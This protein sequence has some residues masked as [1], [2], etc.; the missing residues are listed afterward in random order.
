LIDAYERGATVVPRDLV[1]EPGAYGC[2]MMVRLAALPGARFDETL[3]LYGWLEDLDY[4]ARFAAIGRVARS[5]DCVGVHLGVKS[6]RTP[7]VRFGYSQIANPVYLAGK[8]TMARRRALVM[9]TKNILA[10]SARSLA[11]EPY[12]DRRGRLRGNLLALRDLMLGRAHPTRILD[13]GID[14]AAAGLRRPT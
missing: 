5:G 6:G 7:G 1:D 3:P 4:S 8:G 11:P 14:H 13:L 2:N 10:N 9:A 12:I